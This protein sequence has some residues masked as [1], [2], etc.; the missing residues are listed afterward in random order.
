[1]G[2]RATTAIVVQTFTIPIAIAQNLIPAEQARPIGPAGIYTLT[3]SAVDA[4]IEI[5][6]WYPILFLTAVLSTALA[7]TNLLP[8]PA[9]DGGR[10]FFII[11]EAIR[12]KRVS[13]EKEGAIHFVGFALLLTLM[14]VVS[15]YDVSNPIEP[16]R[17]TDLF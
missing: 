15:Y 14:V 10:I 1:M 7:V 12:G 11:V 13:P 6:A 2:A 4:S 5:G 16:P 8:L 9:L 17:W 3:D